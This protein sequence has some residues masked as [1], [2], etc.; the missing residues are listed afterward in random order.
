[1]KNSQSK[2]WKKIRVNWMLYLFMLPAIV[3]YIVF[4]Y[5]PIYG[6]QIAF[7]D[8]KIGEAFGESTWAGLKHFQRFFKSAWFGTV[9]KNTLT[10]S[11]LNLFLGFPLPIILALLLNEVK[12]MRV[13]KVVQ[14]MTYA[15][16]F[17]SMVI[18]CGTVTMFLSPST[19]IIGMAINSVRETMGLNSINV[20]SRGSAFKWI[21]VL[22]GIWQQ[23]G[24][25]SVIYLAA[26]SGVDPQLL[27]A[28]EMDGANKIQRMLHIN[29]P[30]LIPTIVI[31][32]ILKCGQMLNVGYEKVYLLQNSTILQSS[33]VIST[34]V[35]RSG[36]QGTQYSYSTAVSL[37]NSVVN[38]T[39]LII[40]NQITRKMSK[41][42]SL[43]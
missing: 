18:L 12:N 25:G 35:Y 7:Q 29:L 26:L 5:V 32:L 20:L 6:V 42:N 10:L 16:H 13:R 34:Y 30:V 39:I 38:A 28:A 4:H 19:G 3:Y 36:I 8:Y 22:S 2:I 27:E 43:W 31:Q 33:E 40:V 1:M 15:P 17:I 37:F 9:L 11:L 24:W 14:T 41:E 21:Y 23:T